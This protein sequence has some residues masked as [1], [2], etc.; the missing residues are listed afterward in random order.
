MNTTTAAPPSGLTEVPGARPGFEFWERVWRLGGVISVAVF[1]V[2]HF[3]G[4]YRPKMGAS[5]QTV[6]AFYSGHDTRI[7]MTAA[8]TGF[9]V[10]TLMWFAT[11]MRVSLAEA[12]KDGWGAAATA[13]SATV[14]ALFLVQAALG[15]A[16]AYSIARPGNDSLTSG[17]NDLAWTVQVLLA[18]VLA[19]LVM[20]GTFGFWRAKITSNLVFAA[21]VVVVT[22][23][24]A[25]G[26]TWMRTGILTPDGAFQ[27]Y[28]WPV[29]AGVWILGITRVVHR[30]PAARTAW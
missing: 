3:V 8:L 25:A 12:G 28:I 19:M 23:G 2:V 14:G 9:G 11:A 22:L 10:L 1:I 18:W 29:L 4:G 5:A 13:S 24:V 7:L 17:L 16:L 26:C 30:T 20:S 27:R 6:T 15:G 21:G